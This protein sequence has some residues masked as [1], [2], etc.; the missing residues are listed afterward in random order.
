[1]PGSLE[2]LT[3]NAFGTYFLPSGLKRLAFS[4]EFDDEPGKVLGT[5]SGLPAFPLLV[6]LD[7]TCWLPIGKELPFDG[8]AFQGEVYGGLFFVWGGVLFIFDRGLQK[9]KLV[10][11]ILRSGAAKY[12]Q[13]FWGCNTP[14]VFFLQAHV[15][16]YF[17]IRSGAAN[18]HQLAGVFF[19][20]LYVP[21]GPAP[22]PRA[23]G[24]MA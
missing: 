9:P 14:F 15:G 23:R 11:F 2:E 13:F 5:F 16:I 18:H 20:G 10:V 19:C 22:C 7:I 1:M 6:V 17:I 8:V 3:L 4:D 21:F 12:R 24:E